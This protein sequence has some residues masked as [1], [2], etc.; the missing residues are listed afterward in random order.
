MTTDFPA[1]SVD[2]K[3][4]LLT[5]S[6]RQQVGENRCEM[7]HSSLCLLLLNLALA[8]LLVGGCEQHESLFTAEDRVWVDS[9]DPLDY[10]N[11]LNSRLPTSSYAA[12]VG[13]RFDDAIAQLENSPIKEI[14]ENEATA[15]TAGLNGGGKHYYLVRSCYFDDAER[16][17]FYFDGRVLLHTNS[18]LGTRDISMQRSAIV[19]ALDQEPTEYRFNCTLAE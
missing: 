17:A 10:G 12:V 3:F 14:P 18:N 8:A 13:R 19:V 7:R 1:P 9:F 4:P 11:V 5:R 6:S 15:L 2:R 16:N